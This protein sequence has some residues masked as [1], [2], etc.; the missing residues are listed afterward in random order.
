M[1]KL[2]CLTLTLGL[3]ATAFAPAYAAPHKKRV[4]NCAD[5]VMCRKLDSLSAKITTLDASV[6][7]GNSSQA[8]YFAKQSTVSDQ[9]LVSLKAIEAQGTTRQ[10]AIVLTFADRQLAE[11]QDAATVSNQLCL[12]SGFKSGK[13]V[14]VSKKGGWF[15]G[16]TQYLKS[17]VCTY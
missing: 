9:M 15:S 6:K 17:V 3:M 10:N 1:R 2:T 11:G 14:D 16:N 5:R 7:A 8:D 4:S 12:D 13:P